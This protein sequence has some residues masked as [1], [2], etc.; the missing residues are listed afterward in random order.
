HRVQEG[1]S[2][3]II[4]RRYDTSVDRLRSLNGLRSGAILSIGQVLRVR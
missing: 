1:E 3:W 2:L 4:A